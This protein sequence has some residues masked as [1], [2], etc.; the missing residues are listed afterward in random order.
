MD[1]CISCPHGAETFA[2]HMTAK[3]QQVIVIVRAGFIQLSA[4]FQPW[5]PTEFSKM[6]AKQLKHRR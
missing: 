4:L 1:G 3:Q 5:T 2:S 6:G